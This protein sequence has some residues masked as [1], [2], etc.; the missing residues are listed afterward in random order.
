[1]ANSIRKRD[2]MNLVAAQALDVQID[3]TSKFTYTVPSDRKA[4]ISVSIY[5][6]DAT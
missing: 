5:E 3:S 1:M 4:K 6:E 2:E